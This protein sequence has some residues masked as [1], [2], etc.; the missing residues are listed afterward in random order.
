MS[1]KTKPD[2]ILPILMFVA[3]ASTAGWLLG[4]DSPIPAYEDHSFPSKVFGADRNYRI[5]L[6]PD[7]HE[8]N[9]SYPVIY[10]F[11]GHSDRYTVER[12]DEG[13]ETIPQMVDF[14]SSNEVIVVTV[15]GFVEEHYEGFYGGTPWDVREEGGQY[16]FGVYF[17]E[18][19]RHIDETCRTK[20]GRRYRATSGLS[21]GGFM[22]LY[23]SS[24]YPDRIGSASSFNPGPEF[25][26][27]ERGRR[28][29]WRPKDHTATHRN[30][31]IRLIRASGDYISQYHEE[32]R[33]AYAR[34]HAVDF[35]FRQDEY[36]RHWATS[37][38]ETFAFHMRAFED[39]RL[40]ASPDSWSYTTA[41]RS[42]MAWGYTIESAVE[43][44]CLIYLEDVTPAAFLLRTRQWA[45]DGPPCEPASITVTTVPRYQADASYA[46]Q[47]LSVDD[48]Q[49]ERSMLQP[50]SEGRL[51]I[52][53]STTDVVVSVPD[54][55]DDAVPPR[56]LPFTRV[57]RPRLRPNVATAFPLQ[58]YNPGNKPIRNLKAVLS[59]EY[60][61]VVVES[62][63]ASLDLPAG[64]VAT[65]SFTLQAYAG[66]GYF[67][68]A[69]LDLTLT[70]SGAAEQSIPLDVDIIPERIPVP[71]AVE[72]LDGR[73]ITLPTFRQKG[74]QGG[75]SS[76]DRTITEGHGNGNGVLDPGERVT[77]WVQLAQG[78]DP[79]DKNNWYRAKIYSESDLIHEADDIQEQKG[80]EWTSA[81]GRT[82]VI[83]LSAD[84]PAGF[85]IPLLLD[86]ESWSYHYTPDVRYG[87]EPLY[88][89]YQFHR[90]QLF[91]LTIQ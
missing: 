88:Q 5:I 38:A 83:E 86:V 6:P 55:V 11:H 46:V 61:T 2:N 82:N 43:E 52:V 74:N 7:Y 66:D 36:H 35:E 84:A 15:D 58:I 37:I 73:T 85:R 79:F 69:R 91:E 53:L 48:R 18:M 80:L 44:P 67:A 77:I 30:T 4:Q 89:A 63:D 25:Y 42:S 50:D 24:R 71:K 21:M 31:Q 87:S 40:A 9:K 41:Q 72:I 70:S 57:D 78:L 17:L 76:I 23:L 3:T 14:V 90:R 26:V 13:K 39:E 33:D 12:Y 45:P 28:S 68:P 62:G 19:V 8:S 1:T 16:D 20:I 27:G 81:R 60:P 29:L 65:A 32:T 51:R 49:V 47:Q 75:G 22:S 10:Y 64:E 54:A 34:D 59:T 56:L